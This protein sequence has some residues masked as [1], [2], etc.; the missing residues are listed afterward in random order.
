MGDATSRIQRSAS[1]TI[2]SL[3]GGL[4]A[5]VIS[6]LLFWLIVE[7]PITIGIALCPAIVAI[8][9]FW[10]AVSGSGVAPCPGCGA[11]VTGLSTGSNDGVLCAGC[12]KFLE[13]KAGI[14]QVTDPQRVADSPL[15]GTVLPESFAW[16]EMCCLCAQPATRREAVSVSLPSAASTGKNLAVDVLSGGAVT[17]TGGGTRYT[18]EVPHCAAHQHGAELGSHTQGVKIRFRSYPYLRA[19]CELNKT[20]PE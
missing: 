18:V 2:G 6:G 7:G 11:Q 20:S 9:L 8:I 1:S 3:I 10:T 19:F 4:V 14:L 17:S 12:K 15:F 5:A 16:P 13:G